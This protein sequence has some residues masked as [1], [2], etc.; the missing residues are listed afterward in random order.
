MRRI[1]VEDFPAI[2]AVDTEGKS[3]FRRK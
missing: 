1:G 3:L 2:V